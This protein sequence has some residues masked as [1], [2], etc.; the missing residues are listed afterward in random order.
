MYKT[1]AIYANI[2][3]NRNSRRKSKK[4]LFTIKANIIEFNDFL[5]KRHE[6]YSPM[7][8]VL[9]ISYDVQILGLESFIFRGVY[10]VDTCLWF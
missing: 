3:N 1:Y 9:L 10:G 4:R 8:L 6:N 5:T 7:N 2:V